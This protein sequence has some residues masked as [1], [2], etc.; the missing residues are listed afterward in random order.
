MTTPT[1]AA[2]TTVSAESSRVEIERTLKRY[3]A[4]RLMSG[5]DSV[6]ALVSF[7]AQGRR[8]KFVLPMPIRDA[9]AYDVRHRRR[10][11]KAA[12]AA[13]EQEVRRRWRC[14]ALAIK[15]KLEV[16]ASG[17]ATFEEEFMANIVL[18]NGSTVGE[19]AVP[20][21]DNAYL[22]GDMPRSLPSGE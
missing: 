18:P 12:Q 14:L 19:W 2:Q 21:I 9:F 8:V 5:Y 16:V 10:T 7:E 6:M 17:I 22:S 3:G 15:A 13:Y 20:Q 1:Y 4:D 11:P